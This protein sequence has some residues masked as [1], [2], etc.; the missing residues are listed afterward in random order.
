TDTIA[1]FTDKGKPTPADYIVD[2]PKNEIYLEPNQ[3]VAF[4]IQNYANYPDSAKVMVGLSVQANASA[5][6]SLNGT[7][8]TIY[9]DVDVYYDIN[10]AKVQNAP[11]CGVVAITNTSGARV[12]ITN[13]KISGVAA[14]FDP[15]V[16][17]KA[18]KAL[19]VTEAEEEAFE[20]VVMV[21]SR[22]MRFM[23]NPVFTEADT[24]P[25]P[26]PLPDP[27]P[28]PTHQP[29]IQEWIRQ[30]FSDFVKNLFSSI[31][32]LFGN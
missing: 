10:V 23:E 4:E 22:L 20:P 21:S 31:G 7:S 15:T 13:L 28:D 3:S 16:S 14:D 11:D 9:S 25:S 27:T 1:F 19:A 6:V 8:T 30:L 29:T 17:A 24:E 5:I 26:T 12:A 18:A 2:G 32:R